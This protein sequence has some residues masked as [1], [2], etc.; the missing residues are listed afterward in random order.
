MDWVGYILTGVSSFLLLWAIGLRTEVIHGS[1]TVSDIMLIWLTALTTGQAVLHR[2]VWGIGRDIKD[3]KA[4][5][6]IE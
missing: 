6:G 2:R 3:I 4:H 1:P 5:L